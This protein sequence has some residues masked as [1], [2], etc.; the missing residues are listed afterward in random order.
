MSNIFS[1]W[2]IVTCHNVWWSQIGFLPR[3]VFSCAGWQLHCRDGKAAL[4]VGPSATQTEIGLL[5]QQ[6]KGLP[7]NFSTDIYGSQKMNLHPFG[8]HWIFSCADTRFKFVVFS[9]I[10]W[11]QA[12]GLHGNT[13]MF[14]TI[15]IWAAKEEL[16]SYKFHVSLLDGL[17]WNSQSMAVDSSC[18]KFAGIVLS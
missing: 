8:D 4:F 9:E 16:L 5:K 15:L 13:Y 11:D 12:G 10:W 3:S 14:F 7:F 1:H 2:L 18:L 17:S 6:F